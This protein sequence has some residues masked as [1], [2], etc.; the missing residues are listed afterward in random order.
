MGGAGLV[1]ARGALALHPALAVPGWP[2]VDSARG[3]AG[4]DARP[5]VKS[6]CGVPRTFSNFPKQIPG[7]PTRATP[8]PLDLL[9][10]CYWHV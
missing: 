5:E 1:G 3:E 7:I 2:G 8:L 10:T 6:A 4:G 9:C